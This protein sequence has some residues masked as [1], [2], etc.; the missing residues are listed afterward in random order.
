ME[1]K[2]YYQENGEIIYENF[3]DAFYE[4]YDR[5]NS[6][7]LKHGDIISAEIKL[8]EMTDEEFKALPKWDEQ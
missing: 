5:C 3:D 1:K 2:A 7:L 8:I 6:G 4:A